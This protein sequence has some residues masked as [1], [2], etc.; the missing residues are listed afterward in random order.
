MVDSFADSGLALQDVVNQIGKRLGYSVT[1]GR[2]R[3]VVGDIGFDGVWHS[4]DGHGIIVE[5]KTTDAYRIDLNVL[6]EYR[7]S[8]IEQQ[9][10]SS[11]APSI[12]IVV[13]R[14]D[15]GDLEAQIRGSRYAWDIR[16]ISVDALLR[17]MRLKEELEDPQ[18]VRKIGEI[19]IPRE[20]TKVDGI[21]D[22][23]F[24]TAEDV[25]QDDEVEE[26]STTD[27]KVS[28]R[29]PKFTPVNFHGACVERVQ[30]HLGRTF[31]KQSRVTYATADSSTVLIC[32]VSKKHDKRSE[33]Y[34][35]FAFH[36]HQQD[37]LA[38]AKDA[39]IAFG[40]G[41]EEQIILIPFA[42]FAP[43]LEGMNTTQQEDRFYWHVQIVQDN[44]GFRLNRKKGQREIDLQP[45]L[46]S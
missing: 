30:K 44:S 19:L 1:N 7:R 8:L 15:T 16:L 33:A 28:K 9:A 11:N 41:S 14:Q 13:G 12:L 35:W 32:S 37:T 20:Y 18:I 27:T 46:I 40:C 5:V 43:W 4:S 34:Y 10:I 45:F 3:G 26:L 17:L 39:Y 31:I 22:I 23:V 2:Y 36:P 29:E 38:A 25:R 21:I 24:T 42:Q 6:A